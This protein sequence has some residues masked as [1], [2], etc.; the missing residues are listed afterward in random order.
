MLETIREYAN[1][2]LNGE[3]ESLRARHGEFF[4][5]LSRS[6]VAEFRESPRTWGDRLEADRDNLRAAMSWS[7]AEKRAEHAHEVATAYGVL[8]SSRGPLNEGRSWLD[9][10][11]RET[12]GV[13]TTLRQ[14]ALERAANL[15]IR[16]RDIDIARGLAE[17]SLELARVMND[18]DAI[19]VALLQLGTNEHI[20]GNY[21]QA[22]ALEREALGVFGASGNALQVRQTL[23]LLGNLLFENGKYSEA[24]EV[25]EEALTMS[26]AA[27]DGRNAALAAT[28]LG[29]V[30]AHER[31][32]E[33]ALRLQREAL[34]LAHELLD[35]QLVVGVLLD[36][37]AL[38][39]SL[40]DHESAGVL[41]T[42]LAALTESIE[43]ALAP[44]D[45]DFFEEML[46]EVHENLDRRVLDE[47]VD[48]GRGLPLDD[49]VAYAVE[50]IDS[51]V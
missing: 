9:V 5:E 7:L 32:I 33:E 1:E 22:E 35:L 38:A 4:A 36:I 26:R 17:E 16:H 10:A 8:C 25:C 34:L 24:R 45:D 18:A 30:L 47:V 20:A 31:K 51:N 14:R 27:G 40:G 23:G 48:A 15:A 2:R 37:A 50:F 44:A 46:T 12:T 39:V 11:L 42:A 49:L 19:G 41:L 3:S 13:P 29:R 21:G 6:A 43:F 28:N